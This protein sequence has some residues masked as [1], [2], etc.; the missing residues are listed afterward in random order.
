MKWSNAGTACVGGLS[1]LD[2]SDCPKVENDSISWAG[3]E[4]DVHPKYC[5]SKKTMK[6]LLE[7]MEQ[8]QRPIPEKMKSWMLFQ[9][10][11]EV[12]NAE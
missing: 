4:E 11:S 2:A 5:L 10:A 12:E 6:T 3:L 9:S 1:M 8:G 7:N